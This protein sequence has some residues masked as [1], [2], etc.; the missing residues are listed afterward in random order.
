MPFLGYLSQLMELPPQT[1]KKEAMILHRLLHL[2]G[3]AIDRCNLFHLKECGGPQFQS[4][5]VMNSSALVRTAIKTIPTWR[6]NYNALQQ[7]AEEHIPFV[8]FE[9]QLFWGD[10]W[11]STAY[12]M[13]LHRVMQSHSA[14]LVRNPWIAKTKD[15]QKQVSKLL[16]AV[17]IPQSLVTLLIGRLSALLPELELEVRNALWDNIFTELNKCS[18]RISM[19]AVKTFVNGWATTRRYHEQI[20][21]PCIF[22]CKGTNDTL[23]HYLTCKRLWLVTDKHCADTVG[24]SVL[25]RL[26]LRSPCPRKFK[27]LAI[28]FTEYHALKLSHRDV[29][30]KALENRNLKSWLS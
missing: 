17:L 7:A 28:A 19:I 11:D 23:E 14:I 18:T 9:K 13:N 2:P 25:H 4:I 29:I 12:V 6:N 3:T 20:R 16:F 26:G 22:G 10:H 30:E 27:R 1:V 5:V 8:R 24:T 15:V 21:L